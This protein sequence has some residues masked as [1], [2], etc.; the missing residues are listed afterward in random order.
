MVADRERARRSER[1]SS[2]S[3]IPYA[4]ELAEYF[5]RTE[6][7]DVHVVRAVADAEQGLA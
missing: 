3:A 7:Y 1:F 4:A 2:S 6:G 5:L